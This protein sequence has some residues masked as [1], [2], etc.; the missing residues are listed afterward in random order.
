M[1]V[2]VLPTW[3]LNSTSRAGQAAK[4]LIMG[5][6]RTNGCGR[7]RFLGNRVRLMEGGGRT[8]VV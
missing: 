1:D 3:S 7:S 6:R 5:G 4:C 8:G 2:A